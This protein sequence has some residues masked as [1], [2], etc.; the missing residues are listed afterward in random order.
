MLGTFHILELFKVFIIRSL[1]WLYARH[2]SI[3]I[4]NSIRKWRFLSLTF[5]SGIISNQIYVLT[6]ACSTILTSRYFVWKCTVFWPGIDG[7]FSNCCPCSVGSNFSS[8]A[9]CWSC[10][11]CDPAQLGLEQARLAKSS[12][13]FKNEFHNITHGAELTASS[14][15][16]DLSR[17]HTN[18]PH[19]RSVFK[20]CPIAP[21]FPRQRP[22]MTGLEAPYGHPQPPHHPTHHPHI[23]GMSDSMSVRPQ[24]AMPRPMTV[25]PDT[26]RATVCFFCACAVFTLADTTT[27]ALGRSTLN[28]LRR[29]RTGSP[30]TVPQPPPHWWSL[31]QTGNLQ[32]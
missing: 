30:Q 29:L 19:K 10:F 28:W 25:C 17:T 26:L 4:W 14:T 13:F 7:L 23:P 22:H 24:C 18:L 2:G 3:W 27:E 32:Q 8:N 5:F 12:V 16:R 9:R 6:M 1:L 31:L 20:S 11:S 21:N 15:V